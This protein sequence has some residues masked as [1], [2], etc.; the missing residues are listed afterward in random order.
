MKKVFGNVEWRRRERT[1]V[2][3]YVAS[4]SDYILCKYT[5]TKLI[6]LFV[7]IFNVSFSLSMLP[8]PLE[9]KVRGRR[10]L[11]LQ[12]KILNHY[13]CGERISYLFS[14]LFVSFD[15]T[16]KDGERKRNEIVKDR[17]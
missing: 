3:Y 4:S 14:Y 2:L 8:M 10:V 7:L 15:C 13:L 16:L 11:L 17:A 6:G 1:L 5:H 9:E 12:S